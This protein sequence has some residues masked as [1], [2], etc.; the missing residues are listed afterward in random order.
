MPELAKVQTFGRIVKVNVKDQ[1]VEGIGADETPDTDGEIFDYEGSKPYIEAWSNK[2]AETTKAAGQETSYGNIRGQHDAKV[3]AGRV[4]EP[5]EFNDKA[6]SVY[7]VTKIVDKDEFQKCLEGVYT[8]FSV[9]GRSVRKWRDGRHTRYVVDP[10]E[11]SLVDVPCN[12]GATFTAVKADGSEEQHEFLVEDEI[13]KRKFSAGD[14][15]KLADSGKALP[16]GS[17]PIENKKDLENAIRAIGRAK[18]EAAAKK[19]IIA[20]AKDLGATD[21]LP[22]DWEGSTKKAAGSSDELVEVQGVRRFH[23]EPVSDFV[24]RAVST[25]VSKAADEATT[26][27]KT[28]DPK[29]GVVEKVAASEKMKAARKAYNEVGSCVGGYCNHDDASKCAETVA[30]A[31]EHISAAFEDDGK[32]S[33]KSAKSEEKKKD[34]KKDDDED[35]KA[36]GDKKDEKKKSD[37]KKDDEEKEKSAD[38]RLNAIEGKVDKLADLVTKMAEQPGT[39]RNK[40]VVNGTVVEKSADAKKDDKGKA[41]DIDPNDP[42]RVEKALKNIHAGELELVKL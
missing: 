20:R 27:E 30:K 14:R 35:E 21:M 10:V 13:V 2:Q 42:D 33:E 34:D 7:L 19:H 37:D 18:D 1:T 41:A 24:E 26:K 8:G 28:M 36:K 12:P 31:Q 25:L 29:D 38:A 3:A 39:Q 6:K 22:P 15:K 16:D 9:K 17:F 11:F 23:G 4:A 32:K 5:I 40:P